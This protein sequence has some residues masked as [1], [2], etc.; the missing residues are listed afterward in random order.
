M[1]KSIILKN[2]LYG[3]IP[4][5]ILT[6]I[7]GPSINGS[8]L[9]STFVLIPISMI[10]VGILNNFLLENSSTKWIKIL[11]Y[12]ISIGIINFLLLG[13]LSILGYPL[14]TYIY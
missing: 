2:I 5:L 4:F 7:I 12:C 6:M 9:I 11:I 14:K 13:L 1:D 8:V 10:I 3:I